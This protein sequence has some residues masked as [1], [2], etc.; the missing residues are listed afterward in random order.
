MAETENRTLHCE[1]CA[2]VG[3]VSKHNRAALHKKK[4]G[5]NRNYSQR[6]KKQTNAI[7]HCVPARTD[8]IAFI[9]PSAQRFGEFASIRSLLREPISIRD[10]GSFT[11]RDIAAA[12]CDGSAGATTYPFQ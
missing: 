11:N 12:S 6:K 2:Q 10:A 5:Q 1:N 3:G 4:Q 8:F 9:M 7:L